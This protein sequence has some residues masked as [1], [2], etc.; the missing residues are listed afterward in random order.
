MASHYERALGAWLGQLSGDALGSQVEFLSAAELREQYPQGLV[1]MHAS[2]VWKT[3]AGQPTDDSELAME[4][5]W[6]LIESGAEPNLDRVAQHYMRWIQSGP[7]DAGWTTSQALTGSYDGEDAPS[8]VVMQRANRDSQANGAL[9]RQSPLAI[10]GSVGR[11]A[12]AAAFATKDALLTHP[13]PV[14][15][16]SSRVFVLVLSQIIADGLRP[17]EAYQYALE[18]QRR[19]GSEAMVLDALEKAWNQPPPISPHTGHVILALHNAFYQLIHQ[20]SLQKVI[21]ESVMVGGDTDTNAA[22]AGALAGGVYG[23]RQIPRPWR[24]ALDQCRPDQQ[25][26]RPR[27]ERYWPGEYEVLVHQLLET[28]G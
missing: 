7:F 3:L 16:D 5:A 22:I 6:A 28:A 24:I 8:Q 27:P 23:A 26:P 20:R 10:W 9:M 21:V 11:Q 19:W 13:H 1:A 15:Q 18:V 25:S 12:A 2:P 14:C 4:L 17:E